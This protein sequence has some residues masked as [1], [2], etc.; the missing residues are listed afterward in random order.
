MTCMF[1][2]DIIKQLL[3]GRPELAYRIAKN[4]FAP[5]GSAVVC[6]NIEIVKIFLE[7]DPYLACIGKNEDEHIGHPFLVAAS[8][9]LVSIAEEI[10][11]VCPD[12]AYASTTGIG[13]NAAHIA[14]SNDKLCFLDY[15]IRTPQLHRLI[16]QADFDGDLPLHIAAGGCKPM[17]LRSLM[18]YKRQD[19]TAV[20]AR[21]NNV[22][23]IT[24]RKPELTKTLKWV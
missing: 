24:T 16:N 22:V 3:K 17:F 11:R 13:S 21:N 12:S 7:H 4:G 2:S 5:L 23:D 6:G 1:P 19:Y 9:G 15:I 18:N 8:C 10:I 14:I 20:N